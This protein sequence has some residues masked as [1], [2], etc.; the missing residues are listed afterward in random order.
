MS[1]LTI[2][3][4]SATY[5]AM[6]I[7]D[8][9][10]LSIGQG[11]MHIL[12]GPSGCG[13]TTLLRSIAG[14]TAPSGGE[15]R[16]G[17]RR[18]DNLP[19]KERGIA[20]VFQHY[21][22]FP[23]MTV[24]QNLAFGLEQKR[25]SRAEVAR[26][27]DATLAMVALEQRAD[28]R[29]HQLS[30]GQRQRVALARA[31]VLEPALLLLDEPLS[32]LDAQIRKRLRDEL[33]RIQR[34]SGLTS[35]LVTHDQDEALTL[36]DRVSVMNA[37]RI[38]QTG[39]PREIYHRP[40]S[41]FVAGFIGDGNLL[42][43]DEIER[44]TG[45]RTSGSAIIQPQDLRFESVNGATATMAPA[46]DGEIH[47][48]GVVTD[49]SLSGPTIRYLVEAKGLTLKVE[50]PNRYDSAELSTGTTVRLALRKGDIHVVPN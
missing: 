35:I 1:Y 11:E 27:V 30:G 4:V 17:D 20:M 7:L 12:L 34:E 32:A 8:G 6:T 19:P 29:P 26:K 45:I 3:N 44:L 18:I 28:M 42:T 10:E 5:G 50:A 38:A 13:K 22:L 37:G 49:V 39:T 23:N 46:P 25:L 33:K 16:L 40:D 41:L 43:P 2:A 47:V 31:L 24:R 15:I 9:I 48:Q 36:G 21:A 14:L